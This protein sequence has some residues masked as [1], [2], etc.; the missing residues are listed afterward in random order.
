MAQAQALHHGGRIAQA[1]PIYREVLRRSPRHVDALH[2]PGHA[3]VPGRPP[4]AAADLIAQALAVDPQDA[5]AHGNLGYA[6]HVLGRHDEALAKP[7]ARAGD[8]SPT[9]SRR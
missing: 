2:W 9:C 1:E 4:Q 5:S 3:R 6:L 7:R 8:R